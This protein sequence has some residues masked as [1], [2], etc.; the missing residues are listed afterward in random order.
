MV[1]TTAQDVVAAWIGPDAPTDL[2][3]VETWIAKAER[4]VRR[5]VPG[6]QARLDETDPLLVEADLQDTVVDVVTAMVHRVFRNPEGIRQVGTTTGPFSEQKTYGGDQPGSLYLTA[7][8]LNSLVGSVGET[9]AAYT[10]D[11]IPPTSLYSPIYTTTTN[12][13]WWP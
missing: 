11:M 8:E 4:E 3:Q 10:I 2:T 6:I 9:G 1:W 13:E 7:D 5:N 12:P